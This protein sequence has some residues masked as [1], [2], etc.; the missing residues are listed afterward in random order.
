MTIYLDA[1]W[2]L[3]FLLDW[4]ILLLVQMVTRDNTKGIKILLGAFIASILV[5]I[6]LFLPNTLITTPFGKGIYS[7]FIVLSAFG[8]KN[9]RQFLKKL[10]TFYFISFALGGGLI[11]LHFMLGQQIT[12]SE[13][14]ILTFRTGYGDQISWLF[15]CIGFPFVWWFTKSRL[16]KHALEKFKQDQLFEVTIHIRGE[17]FSTTGYMDSGNQLVDPFS[18]KPVIIC[19][20]GFMSNWFTKDE[21]IQ[22]EKAQENLDFDSV[23][24]KWEE[25]IQVVPY[26]GVGGNRTF[27]IVLK[28]DKLLLTYE[29]KQISTTKILIGIQFR[30][31]VSDGSYHCLLHPYILKN[32]VATSA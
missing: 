20:Q 19:D 28:P 7:L 30:E 31:L 17:G 12:A 23:P 21:L 6:T 8:Y 27:M 16:D 26:Q 4:M 13:N 9:I 24:S 5:P 14:S 2:L 22:M 32:S 15:V 29:N 18:R 25:S 3:N 10:F 11:A 1:I